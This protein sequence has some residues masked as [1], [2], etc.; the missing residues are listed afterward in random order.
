MAFSWV[1]T[2]FD[3]EDKRAIVQSI[4]EALVENKLQDA[5]RR[6]TGDRARL[7]LRIRR[8]VEALTDGGLQLEIPTDVHL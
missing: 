6:A 5:V 4:A 1:T 7:H 8:M 3:E 2:S